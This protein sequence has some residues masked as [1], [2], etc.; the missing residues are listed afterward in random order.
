[1]VAL[2]GHSS[3]SEEASWPA[4]TEAG[5]LA[6]MRSFGSGPSGGTYAVPGG[7]GSRPVAPDGWQTVHSWQTIVYRAKISGMNMITE[8]VGTFY[9]AVFARLLPTV[10]STAPT[11]E[12]AH[13][14]EVTVYRGSSGVG[15]VR[16][17]TG[18][19]PTQAGG[20]V[21][22]AYTE[23]D[24]GDGWGG[25]PTGMSTLGSPS[26]VMWSSTTGGGSGASSWTRTT[27]ARAGTAWVD[28]PAGGTVGDPDAGRGGT[29]ALE[30]LPPAPPLAPVLTEPAVGEVSAGVDLD[31]AWRHR[32]VASGGWQGGWTLMV[33]LEP[34]GDPPVWRYWDAGS[35]TLVTGETVNP[36]ATDRVTLPGSLLVDGVTVTVAVVTHEALDGMASPVSDARTNDV[37]TPPSVVVTAPSGTVSEDLTPPMSWTPTTP[38]GAQTAY[39]RRVLALPSGEVIWSGSGTG[40]ATTVDLPHLAGWVNGGT[41]RTQVRIRQTGGSWSAWTDGPDF[42]MDWTPPPAPGVTATDAGTT[43]HGVQ[44][45]LTGV[46]TGEVIELQ[47][48]STAGWVVVST[49]TADADDPTV[50]DVRA[51]YGQA[52][53]YRARRLVTAEGGIVMQGTWGE[54]GPVTST[55]HRCYLLDATAPLTTWRPVS[56]VEESGVTDNQEVAVSRTIGDRVHHRTLGLDTGVSGR[57]TFRARTVDEV[58][59][60][61]AFLRVTDT[62]ELR[63]PAEH[64]WDAS[65]ARVRTDTGSIVVRRTSPVVTD[66]AVSSPLAWRLLTV[67]WT[68]AEATAPQEHLAAAGGTGGLLRLDGASITEGPDGWWYLDVPESSP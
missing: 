49:L 51:P 18:A 25:A 29:V 32:P 14:T 40:D 23:T 8:K 62:I 13:R 5:D 58:G 66:R 21:H 1:M 24:S 61:G 54:S 52:V 31:V 16:T 9:G 7:D 34:V 12:G 47:R 46:T 10:P 17:G 20:A 28:S 43:G 36:G 33:S 50:T 45:A 56:W 11:P 2:V 38:R 19:A 60:L 68:T 63:R 67:E 53:T 48:S 44:V 4:G 22:A 59:T 27:K 65:G 41:H 64:E 26:I 37:V 15:A 35:G 57:W 30:I 3:W 6:I 55:D 39:E 42:V